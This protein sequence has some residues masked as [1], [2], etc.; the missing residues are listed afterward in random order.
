[1]RKDRFDTSS[2]ERFVQEQ[3]RRSRYQPVDVLAGSNGRE[4]IV[5]C[6]R[7]ADPARWS[8]VGHLF[9][10]T[11]LTH[12]GLEEFIIDNNLHEWT[13]DD[14]RKYGKKLSNFRNA[15]NIIF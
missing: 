7:E 12:R 10:A 15:N 14:D 11:F 5:M 8:V 4:F 3:E 2:F 9:D 1:M 13:K 6:S